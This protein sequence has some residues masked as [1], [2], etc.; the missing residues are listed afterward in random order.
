MPLRTM[1]IRHQ[2]PFTDAEFEQF[3]AHCEVFRSFVDAVFRN[4]STIRK[5]HNYPAP[6]YE[7]DEPTL[8]G[9]RRIAS[10]PI[11]GEQTIGSRAE[12]ENMSSYMLWQFFDPAFRENLEEG[13][14]EDFGTG[15]QTSWREV[16]KFLVLPNRGT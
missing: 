3:R 5:Y 10:L 13:I 16:P 12:I 14:T 1:H 6:R 8:S 7:F 9:D 15:V 4:W 11:R 2:R